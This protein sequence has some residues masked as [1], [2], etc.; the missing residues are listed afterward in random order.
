MSKVRVKIC[1]ITSFNDLKLAIEAGTDAIGMVVDVPDSPRNI[2]IEKAKEIVDAT[3]VFVDTVAVTVPKDVSHLENICKE[4]NPT[5]IQIHGLESAHK[6]IQERLLDT[7][8]IGTLKAKPDLK[9]EDIKKYTESYHAILLD[10]YVPGKNGGSGLT[11]DWE[12]SKR[13]KIAIHPKPLILAGGLTPSNVRK[14]INTVKPYAV[15]V[16]TGVEMSPGKKDQAKV[17]EFIKN[18]KEVDL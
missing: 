9:L 15:D 4:I 6:Q 5:C 8:L 1:G 10:S 17:F 3:P 12:I 7:R 2:S 13:I 14:A 18:A 16:S 11:H